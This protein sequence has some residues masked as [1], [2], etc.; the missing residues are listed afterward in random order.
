MSI[1]PSQ[2]HQGSASSSSSSAPRNPNFNHGSIQQQLLHQQQH[3]QPS[4]SSDSPSSLSEDGRNLASLAIS[5]FDSSASMSDA[6]SGSV[7]QAAANAGGSSKK[8]SGYGR[9]DGK[10]SSPHQI[11]GNRAQLS[12]VVRGEAGLPFPSI[13]VPGAAGSPPNHRNSG[14][15][16]RRSQA[17]NGNHLLNFHYD[18]ISRPQSRGPPPRKPRK[19]KPYNKDL[20]LQANYKFVVLDT[21]NYTLES[22][23]PDKMLQWED[24]ICLKYSTP[25]P[26]QCPICLES[27][28]CPQITSCGHIF[29]FPC[30]L[31][32][33][34]MDEDNHK[35]E[36]WK[37]CPLCFM[38]TSSKDLY[39]IYIENVKPYHVGDTLEFTLLSRKKDSFA[40]Y[41]KVE[42]GTDAKPCDSFSKFLLTSDVDLSVRQA[43][44]DLDSWLVRADSGLVDDLEKL[45]Y[46]CAAMEQL[47]QRKKYW[48]DH[49]SYIG[50]K[51]S[52]TSVMNTT[53]EAQ[54]LGYGALSSA[55][56]DQNKLLGQGMQNVMEGNACL[57]QTS[58][59]DDSLE[60]QD[61]S[62]SSSYEERK[63]LQIQSSG[64][65]FANERDAYNFY[66][67][68]DGQHIILH[69][70]NMKCLLNHYGSHDALPPRISGRVLHLETVTQSDAVRRR[71]R[72]LSH[73]PLTTTFQFCEIDLSE[74]LPP[75]AVSPF[76]DEIKKRERQRKQLAKKE[77]EEKIK[78][79][80]VATAD[81]LAMPYAFRQFSADDPPTF[82]MDDFEALGSS[83]VASSSPLVRGERMLFSSV[84]RMGFAAG[85]DSPSLKIEE[86]Q[87]AQ[88]TERTSDSSGLSGSTNQSLRSF[89]NV[90]SIEKPAETRDAPKINETGK[91][92]KKQSRVLLSTAS[93]RR[94]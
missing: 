50:S 13:E 7:A 77:H 44:L 6:V 65:G 68:V 21:G 36:I 19:L 70:L 84:A 61:R 94:Y 3:Q 33:L 27:P 16:R 78:A 73:F 14:S 31:Q 52:N 41:Q 56:S 15:A 40:L 35:G 42:G 23:D 49:Q 34:L 30:I 92:G 89:A 88:H 75:D 62:L 72:F 87:P 26:V 45:P 67:A 37:K 32:Y 80:A 81:L 71:Y 18:P 2:I 83:T 17:V 57:V 55:V 9:S 86:L 54:G 29:C 58:D 82:S 46:V 10:K 22:M 39:T 66:Q 43:I 91:K 11:P 12:A 8:V 51:A 90:I 25:Y 64:S 60:G 4:L 53:S 59:T 93:S 24:I 5:G 79:E 20:F 1:S 38:M 28:L 76:V 74:D 48:L 85:H 47:E 63:T 69:P